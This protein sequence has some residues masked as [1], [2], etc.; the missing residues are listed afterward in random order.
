L[1]LPLSQLNFL[2]AIFMTAVS[3]P[4]ASLDEKSSQ[5]S[6]WNNLIKN[7]TL[8]TLAKGVFSVLFTV[9]AVMT[10]TFFL[11]RL[12]PGNPIDIRI[13]QLITT[14]SLTY[15]QARN[16]VAS[17]FAFDPD[18]PAIEQYVEYM[19]QLVRGD[20]GK[21]ITTGG[22]PV[23]NQIARYL[24]WTLFSVGLSL[25][26]SFVGGIVIGLVMG[27]WR[28]STFDN[29]MTVIAST[30]S[31]IP[32]Y[33]LAL[34]FVLVLGVQ[35]QLFDIGQF[36]GGADPTIAVGFT[37]E[38]I[39]SLLRLALFP[40][41]IYV[42]STIGTWI[43]SMKSSTIST[44]GEDYITVAQARGLSQ[45]R[46]LTA[47]IGR[48]AMLPLVTRLAI[49]VGFILGGSVSIELIFQYPGLGRALLTSIAARDYPTMQGIFL[50]IS[51]GVVLSNFLSDLAL[52][53]LDPRVRVAQ[54]GK[55]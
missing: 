47:Y 20:L 31:G 23:V 46:I 29:V 18:K 11:I 13:E 17:L 41:I 51:V 50:V 36:R 2:E 35:F 27:Y 14:Q 5:K 10:F 1:A 54:K 7:Y 25:V 4:E 42:S 55:L 44:L 21:S 8:R 37:F 40:V 12:M 6:F 3:A 22:T 49:S 28:G 15:E 38:Y 34:L 45:T 39:F 52:G 32:D 19:G 24:P 48:N 33:V 9:W 30:L 43:L 26:I 16:Q 53:W